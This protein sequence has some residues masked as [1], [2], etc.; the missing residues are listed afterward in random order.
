MSCQFPGCNRPRFPGSPACG[1]THYNALQNFTPSRAIQGQDICRVPNCYNATYPNSVGC[2]RTH[3]DL[4][5]RMG[6]PSKT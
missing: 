3:R 1:R 2:S 5:L 4:A 6:Y